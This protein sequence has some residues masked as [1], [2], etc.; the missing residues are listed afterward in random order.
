MSITSVCYSTRED[1]KTALDIK[2]S[3]RV[4]AQIDRALAG[5]RD[6]VETLCNRKF[7]PQAATR[8]FDWP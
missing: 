7:Y 5:A 8:V 6:S 4:N 3:A 1:V 2:E